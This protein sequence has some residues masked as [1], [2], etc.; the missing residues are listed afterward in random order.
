MKPLKFLEYSNKQLLL[1]LRRDIL[2]RAVIFEGDATRQGTASTKWRGDVAGS[3][4]KLAPQ[5]GTGNARVGDRKSPIRKGGGVAFGPHPRDFSTQLP[6]K[7][8][9]LAFRTALSYRYKKGQLII[10][11]DNITVPKGSSPRLLQKIFKFN[12]WGKENG[13]SLLVTERTKERLFKAFKD[14]GGIGQ[15]LNWE[16]V[17]VK[18]LLETGRVIIEKEALRKILRDHSMDLKEEHRGLTIT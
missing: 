15:A 5:K 7:V 8:Y 11:N 9:D 1:P 16:D 13:R 18:K 12:Q 3:R 6:R 2:H 10:V 14:L 17:S 4:K